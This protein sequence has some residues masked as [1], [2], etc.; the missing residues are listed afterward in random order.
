MTL[1]VIIQARAGS[2]RLPRKVLEQ[3]GRKTVLAR[4]IERCQRIPSAD[5]VVCAIADGDGNDAVA[6]EARA[7]GARVFRGSETD[8]LARYAG[9]AREVGA[10]SVV[11]ITSDCP[12]IDPEMVEQVIALQAETGADYANNTLMPGFPRGLDCE[13]FPAAWLFRADETATADEDREHVT[14]WIRNSSTVK[15]ACLKGPGGDA[16]QWRWTLDYA[17]DLDFCRAVYAC[18][19]EAV[20]CMDFPELAAL[21]RAHRELVAIN[22]MHGEA[23]RP[24]IERPAAVVRDYVPG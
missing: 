10:S 18:A 8:V 4:V 13:V 22:A 20:A 2:S 7:A 24:D 16:G 23:A 19:G 9:A 17:E 11:R 14:R 21:C 12:F 5:H 3:L 6:D 15:R 1:A